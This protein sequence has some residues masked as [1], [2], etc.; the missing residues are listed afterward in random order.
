[1]SFPKDEKE[2]YIQSGMFVPVLQVQPT[3]A[4]SPFTS[5]PN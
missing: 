1:M 3:L 2:V 5:F 4:T